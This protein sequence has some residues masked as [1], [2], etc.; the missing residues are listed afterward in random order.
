LYVDRAVKK[1]GTARK[2]NVSIVVCNFN[3]VARMKDGHGMKEKAENGK[4]QQEAIDD[5]LL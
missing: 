2:I 5:R 4:S 3:L 1:I